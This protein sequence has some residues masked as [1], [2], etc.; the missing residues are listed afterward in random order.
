MLL[1]MCYDIM[2]VA[3][4]GISSVLCLVGCVVVH[5]EKHRAWWMVWYGM[6]R[7]AMHNIMMYL[8]S[9]PC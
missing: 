9:D 1:A 7:W 6:H 3:Q 8:A 4:L 5:G 2:C